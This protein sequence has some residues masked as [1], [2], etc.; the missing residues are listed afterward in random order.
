MQEILDELDHLASQKGDL[1]LSRQSD[2]FDFGSRSQV[3]RRLPSTC[4]PRETVIFG[5]DDDKTTVF[6]CLMSGTENDSHPFAVISIVGMGGM[7][8]T[9]LA[10]HIYND[11][12]VESMG[13]FDIKAW[14]CVSDAFDVFKLTR[15]ILEE[16]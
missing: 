7:G 10:Q 14:V 9:T 2:G 12:R 13:K 15:A 5:R 6:D 8:K 16:I 4:L 3:S 1:G 11:P